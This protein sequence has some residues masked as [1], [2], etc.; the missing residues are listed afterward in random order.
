VGLIHL[1]L[2]QVLYSY[3]M[4]LILL[5][6]AFANISSS[7]TLSHRGT[8]GVAL[9]NN[10]DASIY[11]FTTT[12]VGV[13]HTSNGIAPGQWYWE[14]YQYPG[15]GN[16]V[17]I[18]LSRSNGTDGPITQLEYSFTGLTLWYDLSNVNCGPTS[19]SQ[20][21]TGP[22]PFSQGGMF[23]ET[24]QEGCPTSTCDGGDLQCPQAYNLPTDNWAV[25]S[26]KYNNNNLV[27]FLCSSAALD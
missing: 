16:G 8:G 15:D 27:M 11:S 1:T 10:C 17:S 23:L 5:L 24:D 18:K 21:Q 22:C 6:A 19:V 20:S 7:F 9:Y 3:N 2:C 13:V 14:P 25:R 12:P 26:C 4:I